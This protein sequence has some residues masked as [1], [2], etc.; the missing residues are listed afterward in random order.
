MV[1]KIYIG[2]SIVQLTNI[3]QDSN[4]ENS[5]WSGGNYSTTEKL[6]GTRSQYFPANSTT[7]QTIS[8]PTMPVVGHKYYGRHYLKTDGNVTA[9]DCCFEWY[10]GDGPG[11]NYVFGWN[12]GNYPNWTMESS[13]VTVDAVNGS[14]YI[15][16]SF[17]VNGT[18]DVWA[19]GLMIVDLTAAF[20]VGNEPSKEWCDSNISF[21]NES[22]EIFNTYNSNLNSVAVQ[23]KKGYIG[24]NNIA[25]KI[26]RGYIGINNIAR[27][28]YNIL[29]T[30]DKYIS[31]YSEVEGASTSDRSS[32]A[33]YAGTSYILSQSTGQ[34]SVDQTT[35]IAKSSTGA[36]NAVGK[37]YIDLYSSSGTYTGGTVYLITAAS[38]SW[39][40]GLSLIVTPI[41]SQIYK[42]SL[43]GTVTD[44][45]VSSYPVDGK[46]GD[47]WYVL[48]SDIAHMSISYTGS[49]VDQVVQMQSGGYRLLTLTG[50]GSLT[51][52]ETMEADVWICGGGAHGRRDSG[53]YRAYGGGNGGYSLEED[54]ISIKNLTVTIGAVEGYS[55]LTGDISLQT[56]VASNG[57]SSTIGCSGGSGGGGAATYYKGGTGDGVS[58]IPFSDNYFPYPFCGGGGGGSSRNTYGGNGGD[59]GN[60]GGKGGATGQEGLGGHYGGN[61]GARGN[62][63]LSISGGNATGYGSGGGGQGYYN[64]YQ[65]AGDNSNHYTGYG[66]GYQGVCFI[67]IPLEQ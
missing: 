28:W 34:F 10:A 60:D 48:R 30:W 23:F 19:D 4:M 58:K 38:Y 11:L 32:S 16:R 61:G 49:Y 27:L 6:F 39:L 15:C 50:S 64:N 26:V 54:N 56:A 9:A 53:S 59:N 57:T 37:Y 7:V 51:L 5:G 8:T 55:K 18:G 63:T 12:Q 3:V 14:D 1:K 67:R 21:F 41:T 17:V 35:Q 40:T 65:V 31:G 36:T 13:I 25:R 43:V 33:F 20:G 44:V 66:N 46:Q 24:I 2:E 42:G 47:Y 45:D 29:W 22:T 62:A 52:P